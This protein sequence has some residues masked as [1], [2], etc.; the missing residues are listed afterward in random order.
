MEGKEWGDVIRHIVSAPAQRHRPS[1]VSLV[2]GQYPVSLSLIA[3]YIIYT[4]RSQ[5][6]LMDREKESVLCGGGKEIWRT[7]K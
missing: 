2:R 6:I 4:K 5:I 7:R 1:S 3:K